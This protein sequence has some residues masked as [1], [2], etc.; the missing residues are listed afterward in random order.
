VELET[1]GHPL[2]ETGLLL[3]L[4][5]PPRLGFLNGVQNLQQPGRLSARAK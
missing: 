3:Q 4:L 1:A 2:L 5:L